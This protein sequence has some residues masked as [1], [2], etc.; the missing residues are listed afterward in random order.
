[1]RVLYECLCMMRERRD[2]F[3]CGVCD[4]CVCV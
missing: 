1:V 4:V 3:V 2:I